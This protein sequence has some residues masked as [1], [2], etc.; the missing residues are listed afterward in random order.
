MSEPDHLSSQFEPEHESRDVTVGGNVEESA[1]VVSGNNNVI[2][3]NGMPVA[4]PVEDQ[5]AQKP[6]RVLTIVARPLNANELP[7]I[8]DAWSLADGLLAVEAPVE[9]RFLRPPT[10]EQ[11]QADIDAGW[12]IL[13]FDGHGTA[14]GGGFLLFEEENGLGKLLPTERF[15]EML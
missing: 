11:L 14:E 10:V 15:I 4:L 7:E 6:L 9:I 1:V 2:Y 5:V 8:A 13:H 12:D 3:V